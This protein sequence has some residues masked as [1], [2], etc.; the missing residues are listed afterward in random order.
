VADIN[1]IGVDMQSNAIHF[2]RN[3][4]RP[5]QLGHLSVSLLRLLMLLAPRATVHI[6]HPHHVIRRAAL[7]SLQ[8]RITPRNV[9]LPICQSARQCCHAK[10]GPIYRTLS[11]CAIA[12]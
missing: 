1:T 12:L 8:G 7:L 2:S 5:L 9:Q 3:V 4:L 6:P 11:D 10:P